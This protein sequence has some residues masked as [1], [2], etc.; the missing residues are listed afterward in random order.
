MGDTAEPETLSRSRM[1]HLDWNRVPIEQVNP[2]FDRQLIVGEHIMV[3]RLVLRKGC[4]VPLHSHFNE[5]VSNVVSGALRFTIEGEEII[6][7]AG[8]YL[9]I[10]PNLP[11]TATAIEDTIAIDTFSPP[12]ADWVNKT[13]QYL[14]T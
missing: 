7:R 9:C 10:P 1:Q 13:D 14:R 2:L 3:A 8:E 6:L 11:H 5:Q 4:V 12:R